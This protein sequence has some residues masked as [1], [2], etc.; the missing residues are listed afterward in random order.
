MAEVLILTDCQYS[1]QNLRR[2]AGQFKRNL[3]LN[4][5]NGKAWNAQFAVDKL[6]QRHA[7]DRRVTLVLFQEFPNGETLQQLLDS[8]EFQVALVIAKSQCV[9]NEL[10]SADKALIIEQYFIDQPGFDQSCLR[11]ESQFFHKSALFHATAKLSSAELAKLLEEDC[12]ESLHEVQKGVLVAASPALKID[13]ETR[14]QFH[15]SLLRRWRVPMLSRDL[16]IE[17]IAKLYAKPGPAGMLVI[18]VQHH[19]QRSQLQAAAIALLCLGVSTRPGSQSANVTAQDQSKLRLAQKI[20]SKAVELLNA[21]QIPQAVKGFDGAI[22]IDPR[23]AEAYSNR[24][25]AKMAQGQIAAA[26]NDY[27]QAISLKPDLGAAHFNYACGLCRLELGN[28]AEAASRAPDEV[29][30][31]AENKALTALE[32]AYKF[33]FRFKAAFVNDEDLTP[34]KNHPRFQAIVAKL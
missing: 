31:S 3:T 5:A 22:E 28:D 20:Y 32:Q 15:N 12:L 6:G 34:L 9:S 13:A 18:G 21:G 16:P 27:Q 7:H 29:I 10:C 26:L 30:E 2:L 8:Q 14:Q 4:I 25:V 23:Y 19:S 17:L 24:G 33:Q 11:R 1:A